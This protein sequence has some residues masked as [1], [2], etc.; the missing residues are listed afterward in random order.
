MKPLQQ[1]FL[2]FIFSHLLK[3]V[4]PKHQPCEMNLRATPIICMGQSLGNDWVSLLL[5]S[6]LHHDR[7]LGHCCFWL[8]LAAS[9]RET[10]RKSVVL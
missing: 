6:Q 1:D 10:V 5:P 7:L 4:T 9:A 8:V 3:A 2:C